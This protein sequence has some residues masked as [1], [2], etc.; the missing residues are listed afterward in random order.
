M[1]VMKTGNAE[2]KQTNN[3]WSNGKNKEEKATRRKG[4]KP[5]NK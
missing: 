3:K 1:P 4:T 5:I 2:E